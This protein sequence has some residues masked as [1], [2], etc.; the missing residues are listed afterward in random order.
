M[1]AVPINLMAWETS[2]YDFH[3]HAEW[4]LRELVA[5]DWLTDNLN[6]EI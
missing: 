5:D 1:L 6:I 2:E 4:R 3:G